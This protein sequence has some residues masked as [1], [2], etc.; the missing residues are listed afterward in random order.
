[1]NYVIFIIIIIIEKNVVSTAMP[2]NYFFIIFI[3]YTQIYKKNIEPLLK[4]N[5]KVS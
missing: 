1:M 4:I 2:K 3:S 5:N